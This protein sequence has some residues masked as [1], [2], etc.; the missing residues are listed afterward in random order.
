MRDAG[1]AETDQQT[2]PAPDRA[3][4]KAQVAKLLRRRVELRG[5]QHRI[6]LEVLGKAFARARFE[7][8]R[9]EGDP[10]LAR[11]DRIAR[12]H[13]LL[14]DGNTRLVPEVASEEVRRVGGKRNQRR[15]QDER[16]VEAPRQLVGRDL[17]VHLERSG[18]RLQHDVI[19]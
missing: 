9:A 2:V 4:V 3:V 11:L 8:A 16:S 7:I 12:V 10:S 6:A 1:P 17:K 15:R 5:Q 14:E 19:V 18:R 13:G